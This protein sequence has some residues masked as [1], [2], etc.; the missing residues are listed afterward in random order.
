M[1]PAL[2]TDSATSGPNWQKVIANVMEATTSAPD[3]FFDQLSRALAESIGAST[4][5]I[6][7]CKLEGLDPSEAEARTIS[8]WHLGEHLEN[9]TYR[10]AKT[11]CENIF[12]RGALCFGS[13]IQQ[14]FPEDQDLVTLGAESYAAAPLVDTGGAVLGHLAVLDAR[15]FRDDDIDLAI[16]RLLATVAAAELSKRRASEKAA[17][18]EGLLRQ[19]IDLLPHP[20]FAKD[21]DGRFWLANHAAAQG[22]GTTKERLIGGLDRD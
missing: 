5:F 19:I 21:A 15:P 10:I 22:L 9:M 14:L 7:E 2:T 16:L 1:P 17:E 18:R 3:L 8:F 20:V 13:N 11:P 6:T 4:C 12:R